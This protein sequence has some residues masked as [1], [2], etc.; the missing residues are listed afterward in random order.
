[1]F[2]GK[3]VVSKC[4]DIHSKYATSTH[5]EFMCGSIVINNLLLL[6]NFI[7]LMNQ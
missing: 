4:I 3:H 6:F 1:M 5:D 7:S 2:G